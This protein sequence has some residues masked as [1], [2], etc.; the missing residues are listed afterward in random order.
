MG[1]LG[2]LGQLA[3]GGVAA[4]VPTVLGDGWGNAEGLSTGL[5]WPRGP[6]PS[7]TH[8]QGWGLPTD[9]LQVDVGVR[10]QGCVLTGCGHAGRQGV[11]KD[12][13][14]CGTETRSWCRAEGGSVRPCTWG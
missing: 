9:A 10:R 8:H 1:T 2:S 11:R 14:T 3:G 6:P 5:Q 4:A 13:L 7:M 12:A